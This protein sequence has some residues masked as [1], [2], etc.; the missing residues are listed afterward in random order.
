MIVGKESVLLERVVLANSATGIVTHGK[1]DVM[2]KNVE[3][4]NCTSTYFQA[5]GQI[6]VM[7]QLTVKNSSMIIKSSMIMKN[8]FVHVHSGRVLFSSNNGQQQ[9]LVTDRTWLLLTD[10]TLVEFKWCGNVILGAS[11]SIELNNSTL[12]FRQNEDLLAQV[13]HLDMKNGSSLIIANNSRGGVSLKN[14]RWTMGFDSEV[15]VINNID[16]IFNLFSMS[17]FLDG[18]VTIANNTNVEIP[19]NTFDIVNS[20]VKFRPWQ[21]TGVR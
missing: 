12:A 19:F 9:C 3:V 18:L 2:I 10:N 11:S 14:S 8:V 21:S 16:S 15:S 1:S 4:D 7:E 13:S 5:G 20:I 6:T 17:V